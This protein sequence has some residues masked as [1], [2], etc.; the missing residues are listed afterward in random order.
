M[1]S[2]G[3]IVPT[4]AGASTLLD[5]TIFLISEMGLSEKI[6]PTFSFNKA[7]KE[8]NSGIGLCPPLTSLKN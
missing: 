1:I 6:N 5:S 2:L 8:S 4:L 7:F 3:E